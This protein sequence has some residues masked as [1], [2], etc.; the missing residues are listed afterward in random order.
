M[1]TQKSSLDSFHFH[2]F[3]QHRIIICFSLKTNLIIYKLKSNFCNVKSN[4][5]FR[6]SYKYAATACANI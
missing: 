3:I 5:N 2:S 4:L 6:N 1:N